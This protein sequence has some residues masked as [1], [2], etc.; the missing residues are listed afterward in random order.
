[1]PHADDRAHAGGGR[2]HEKGA[3][4]LPDSAAGRAGRRG[5]H[6]AVPRL[7]CVELDDGAD[8]SRQRRLLIRGLDRWLTRTTIAVAS[9]LM[10]SLVFAATRAFSDRAA[11]RAS[12]SGGLSG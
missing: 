11:D 10:L 2:V 9:A 1:H 12:H 8:D 4:A 5:Q 3:A 7:R 6:G